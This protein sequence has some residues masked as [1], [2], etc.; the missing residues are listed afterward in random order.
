MNTGVCKIRLH[1]PESQSLKEKRR[2]IKPIITRLRNMYNVSIAEVDDQDLWQIATIGVSCVSNNDHHIDEMLT[3]VLTFI[4]DSYPNVE[5]IEQEI[6][7]F[8]GP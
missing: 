7:V 8:H 1:F 2:I 3:S 6:E 5:I 4:T